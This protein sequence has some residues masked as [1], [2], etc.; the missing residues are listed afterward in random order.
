V[1]HSYLIIKTIQRILE[2]FTKNLQ[3]SWDR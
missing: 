2:D 3:K 1:G